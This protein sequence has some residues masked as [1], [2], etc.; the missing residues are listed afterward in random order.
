ML[1]YEEGLCRVP[2]VMTAISSS[3]LDELEIKGNIDTYIID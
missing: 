1:L 2:K 3:S